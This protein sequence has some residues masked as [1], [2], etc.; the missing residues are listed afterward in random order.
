M[1]KQGICSAVCPHPPA[2][3]PASV[4][5]FREANSF[6]LHPE[7]R[8]GVLKSILM[9]LFRGISMRIVH[10]VLPIL[11][12]FLF[13]SCKTEIKTGK[14]TYL[15]YETY[16]DIPGITEDEIASIENIKKNRKEFIYGVNSTTESFIGKNHEIEGFSKLLCDRLS[17]LFGIRFSPR[18]Y[19]WDDLND[20]LKENEIDFTGELSPNPERIKIYY[21]TSPMIHR[22]FKIFKNRN[23]ENLIDISKER[24]IRV[25]FLS[26]STTYDMV[27]G[28]WKYQFEP[29]FISNEE[30]ALDYIKNNSIDCYIDESSV[31]SIF[32]EYDF[33]KTDNY[34][35][36][37]YSPLS[38][39]T[40]N[41]EL[42]PF[43]SAIQKYL[44][45]NGISSVSALYKQGN[46]DYQR[47][48]VEKF[49]TDQEKQY[50]QQHNAKDSAVP[51]GCEGDNYPISFYNSED[52]AFQGVAVDVLQEVTRLTGLHFR[53]VN[54][55]GTAWEELLALLEKNEVAL[56]S[57]LLRSKHRDERFLWLNA[58]NYT[59]TYALLSK[60]DFPDVSIN[61]LMNVKVGLV[62]KSASAH[63]EL[64]REW[65]PEGVHTR[66]YLSFPDA[67]QA[68][69]HGEIDLLMAT[70]NLLLS[71]T[72][73][74]EKPGF[75]ANIVFQYPYNSEF[76]LNKNQVV[77]QSILNKAQRFIDLDS[78]ADRWQRKV[79]D[80]N[81]K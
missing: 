54:P 27:N 28:S 9:A 34:F 22:T 36:V 17:S 71:L 70:Q 1:N 46:E 78:I 72:N 48:K 60:A 50:I 11:V 21:M 15:R 7:Q 10:V 74:L 30:E 6:S 53:I 45:H 31:E 2:I 18:M 80:Y 23:S 68:L 55:P 29:T 76:G 49:F 16:R 63:V 77:L 13:G 37:A 65:F 75:K 20:K 51:I 56:V 14:N 32:D 43:I 42:R 4:N 3:Q 33:I 62:Q 64:F 69:E 47:Y 19:G 26:G 52:K 5:P 40:N 41:K 12:I 66:A 39:T 67:F 57:E 58:P 81:S 25:A 35:P 79:F 59:D 8:R 73:Y 44:D 61:E 38:I 24:P